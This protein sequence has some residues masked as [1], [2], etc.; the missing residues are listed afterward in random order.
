MKTI[1]LFAAKDH[2][3]EIK[4]L[5]EQLNAACG[6]AMDDGMVIDYEV[7]ERLHPSG[8]RAPIFHVR[9]KVDPEAV[10]G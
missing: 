10:E 8:T 1:T 3:A 6:K 9:A 5:A 7:I 2:A 4:D